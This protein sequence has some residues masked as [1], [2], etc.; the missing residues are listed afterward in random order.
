[1]ITVKGIIPKKV[2]GYGINLELVETVNNLSKVM[3]EKYG[4]LVILFDGLDRIND[5]QKFMQLVFSDAKAISSAG[6]GLVLVGPLTAIYGNYRDTVDKILDYFYYQPFFDIENDQDAYNFFEQIL[7]NRS[8]KDF[9]EESAMK[10]LIQFSGGVLR[11]FITLT[12]ASLEETYISGDEKVQEKQVL[13]A[14]D[15]IGRN[16]LLGLSDNELKI[17]KQML[18]TKKFI[19]ITDEDLRLLVRRVILEYRYPKL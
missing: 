8:S 2:E 10:A 1:M 15:S 7:K 17:I 12:Q 6:I 9:I 4:N 11:D 13:K 18:K 16:Q 19:P 5:A 3:S 14:V